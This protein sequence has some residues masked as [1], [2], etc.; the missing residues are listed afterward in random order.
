[1]IRYII[2]IYH[3]GSMDKHKQP[4]DWHTKV[5]AVLRKNS[6]AVSAYEVLGELRVFN[7]KIA[8]PTVYRALN[9]LAE[10]GEVHRLESMNAYVASRSLKHQHAPV[11]SIC[12]DCGRVEEYLAPQVISALSDITGQTGF[13]STRQVIELHGRCISCRDRVTS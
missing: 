10:R 11:L 13:T 1:M 12:D 2:S 4:S 8:P 3:D 9:A 7:P 5:L 6:G